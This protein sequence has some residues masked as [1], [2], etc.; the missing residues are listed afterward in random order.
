[1]RL[2]NIELYYKNKCSTIYKGDNLELL[3]QLPDQY[4]D[5]I[6]CDILYG[7]GKKFKDYQDLKPKKEIIEEFYEPRLNEMYRVL[8]DTGSIYLQMDYRI[9]HWVRCIMDNIF[10]YENFRNKIV[11]KYGLGNA[12]TE[13]NYLDKHDEILYYSKTKNFTWNLQRG[14]VTPQMKAKYCH[15]D[16]DEQNYYMMSNNKKYYL[17]GGKKLENVWDDIPNMSSTSKERVGYDTQKPKILVERIIKGSS[18]NGDVV[19]DF[20][21]GSGTTGDVAVELG[22]KFIGCDISEKACLIAKER[23][24]KQKIK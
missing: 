13:T 14:E 1:M 18:N 19:A 21:M 24:Q 10:T 12:R 22:R 7:T 16:E 11:W 20:F 4:V 6:Y 2:L 17:K 3:K 5:L 15:W 8:K 23:L 9:S